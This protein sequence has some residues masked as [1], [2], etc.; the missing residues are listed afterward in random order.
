MR[1]LLL[2]LSLALTA[3]MPATADTVH[4]PARNGD[5]Y[6]GRN[7]QPT[8]AEVQGRERRAGVAPGMSDQALD[9]TVQHLYEEL[10]QR[11]RTD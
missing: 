8:R 5:V 9:A 11:A 6:G 7:H 10:Q 2:T 1:T 3:G 4:P